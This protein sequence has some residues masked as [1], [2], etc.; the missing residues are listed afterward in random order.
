M[1][2]QWIKFNTSVWSNQIICADPAHFT[3]WW[4]LKSHAAFRAHCAIYSGK[5]IELQPGQLITG[6]KELS[7]L[8]GIDRMRVTRILKHFTDAGLITQR[9]NTKG[10]VITVLDSEKRD[11]QATASP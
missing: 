4:Y 5:V 1:K 8:L 3:V 11:P 9:V 7:E 2:E 10:R 6:A